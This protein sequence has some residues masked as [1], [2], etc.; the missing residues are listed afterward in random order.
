MRVLVV[1]DDDMTL[2]LLSGILTGCGHDVDTAN[3]GQEALQVLSRGMHRV[4]ISDWEMPRLSGPDLCAAIRQGEFGGYIYTILLTS[5]NKAG[6]SVAGL[7]AGADDFITKPVDPAQLSARVRIAERILSL[8]T[9]DLTIF[10]MAK[11]AESRD[12]ETGGHLD[13]VR[14]YCQVLAQHLA[15]TATP[16]HP[17]EPGYAH[18]IYLTSPLHD[19]GKVAIPDH[20]L[21]KPGR[22]SDREFE[23]MKTHATLGAQTLDAAVKEH[24]DAGFLRMARNI[25]A[26]H[27]ERWDGT[28]YPNG[29]KGE[30]IP[31]CGRVVAL[32]DVY[33][34]LTSKRVYKDAFSH[35]IAKAMIIKESGTHFAPEVVAAFLAVEPQFMEIRER[36]RDNHLAMAA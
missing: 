6:D 21:L 19:I 31:L 36:F 34:A 11:L 17:L 32:A 14:N 5:R 35:D 7:N 25:A 30:E 4:V 2:E 18:M 8:Q 20:V 23:I 33:D 28:G 26:T 3:D 12:P 22:L 29:L 16:E 13:R 24:P 10:A 15:A 9:R 27:H 1:D